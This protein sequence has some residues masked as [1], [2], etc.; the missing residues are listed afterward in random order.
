MI[1]VQK[2][3]DSSKQ[4]VAGLITSQSVDRDNEVFDYDQSKQYFEA[5]SRNIHDATSKTADPGE[6]SYGNLRRMHP[7]KGLIVVGKFTKIEFDDSSKAIY[8]V[9]KITDTETWD[10]V[11]K[12]VLSAFSVAGRLISA[13][14][15]AGK[16]WLTVDPVEVSIVD[17]PSNPDTT[18]QW[19]KGSG[20]ELCVAK[21]AGTGPEHKPEEAKIMKVAPPGWEDTVQGMKSHSDVDNPWALAWWMEGEGYT[22]HA[23]TAK[24]AVHLWKAAQAS[25]LRWVGAVALANGFKVAV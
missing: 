6:E 12:G 8:G 3:A 11:R 22:P 2:L 9:A 19:A 4:E 1:D 7:Q 13:V 23:D 10:L 18:L 14:K 20:I 24:A 17:Y 15:R 16:R 21:F 25:G 5:W